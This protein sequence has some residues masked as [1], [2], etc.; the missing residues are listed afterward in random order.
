MRCRRMF[1]AAGHRL[2]LLPGGTGLPI[3]SAAQRIRGR[4]VSQ[5]A[6]P[7]FSM[8]G[9]KDASRSGGAS[10][11]AW[12][13]AARSPHLYWSMAV[14]LGG[15]VCASRISTCS[16]LATL[17]IFQGAKRGANGDRRRATRGDVLRQ[18]MQLSGS[19]GDSPRRPATVRSR[20]TSE[21]SLVRTQLRPRTDFESVSRL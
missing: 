5:A 14:R 18:T 13:T 20:L 11:R 10:S 19:S 1:G 8:I 7:A 3:A 6:L 4:F 21:G 16:S 15:L 17:T 12:L 2:A 9:V